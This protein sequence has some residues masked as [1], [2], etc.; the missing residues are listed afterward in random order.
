MLASVLWGQ[1]QVGPSFEVASIKQ[2]APFSLERMRSGQLHVGNVRGNKADF[3]FVSLADLITYAYRVKPYQISGPSWMR[4]GRW[5]I[6]ATL[7]ES[8]SPDRVPEMVQGLLIE[9]FKLAHHHESR[10]HP[11]YEV[12]VDKGGLKLK[13]SPP[14][15]ETGPRNGTAETGASPGFSVGGFANGSMRVGPGGT[16]AVITGGA[17][18]ITRVSQGPNGGMRME[19]SRMTMAALADMLT[20]FMDRPVFDGTG[21]KE[22]YQVTIDL[23]YDAMMRV[24]QNL[25]GTAGMPVGFAGMGAGGFGGWPADG[26]A[27]GVGTAPGAASDPT[28]PSVMQSVQPLGLRL[29]RSRA[30]VDT[31]VIDHLEKIPTEN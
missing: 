29:Q 14:D 21:L 17:N 7:P 18:G 5:D 4:D 15:D 28:G 23:P 30:P 12:V 20:P 24:I 6:T 26:R 16:G 25:S 3:Q 8:A 2:A 10:E 1:T 11:V 19:M 31:I 9:R 13:V 27:A 22:A